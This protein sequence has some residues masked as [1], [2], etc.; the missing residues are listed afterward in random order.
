MGEQDSIS[1]WLRERCKNEHLSLREAAART[2]LSHATIGDTIKGSQP[3]A[4]TI[5]K[6]AQAFGGDGP[7]QRFTLEDYLLTLAGYRS[8]RPEEELT[9]P[10][11]QLI[12]TVRQFD[13]PQLKM[14]RRFANF[15][16]EIEAGKD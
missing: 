6:L 3:S 5:R 1:Q 10:L 15:L 4:E 12:D 16:M 2:G 11:A 8:E 9:E 14:M 13:E 7:N